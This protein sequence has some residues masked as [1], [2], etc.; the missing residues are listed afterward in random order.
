[1]KKFFNLMMLLG[2]STG[3]AFSKGSPPPT[4]PYVELGRYL[5]LWHEIARLP[6]FAQ[7]G[8]TDTTAN[9]SLRTDGDIR[10]ENKCTKIKNEKARES[11]A[12]GRAWIVDEKSNSKLKVRFVWWLPYIADGDYW[13]L[14]LDPDY[15]ISL[16]GTPDRKYLWLLAREPEMSQ[17]TY[18]SWISFAKSLGYD[19]DQLIVSNDVHSAS[20][21]R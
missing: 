5:G 16:V 17:E 14:K 15:K 11:T 21:P 18:D 2:L 3:P 6:M 19:T 10:V 9:Y 4:V 8:C 7:K 1:M 20:S 12:N 13:V